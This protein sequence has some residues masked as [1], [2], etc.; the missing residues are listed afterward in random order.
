MSVANGHSRS[1]AAVLWALHGKLDMV[2]VEMAKLT[3]D[4]R[5][6]LLRACA[7]VIGVAAPDPVVPAGE[8][9]HQYR[10]ALARRGIGR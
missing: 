1:A 10:L 2:E 5:D 7:V 4:E 9:R 8:A 3:D 6:A